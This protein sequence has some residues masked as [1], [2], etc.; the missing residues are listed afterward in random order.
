V[1]HH[2]LLE[3]E[4]LDDARYDIIVMLQPTSPMRR[5]EEVRQAIRMLVNGQWDSVWTVSVTD[6]KSHPLKQ[7]TLGA[8]CAMGYYDDRGATIIAR[9]QLQPVYH[10]NGVAYAIR[11]DCLKEQR[12]INGARTGALVLSDHHVSIDTELDFDLV[13]FMLQREARR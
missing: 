4:R 12:T 5:P 6:S 9:Q 1:L 8:D 11:R 10:R 3:M 7:L 2:A 13:E